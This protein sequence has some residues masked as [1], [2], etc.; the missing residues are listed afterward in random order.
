MVI[1]YLHINIIRSTNCQPE[2]CNSLNMMKN[3]LCTYKGWQISRNR[4][5]I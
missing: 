2:I 4:G 3:H 1:S 5:L